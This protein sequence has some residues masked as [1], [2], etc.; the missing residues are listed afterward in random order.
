MLR[1]LRHMLSEAYCLGLVSRHIFKTYHGLKG[2]VSF[3]AHPFRLLIPAYTDSGCSGSRNA[4]LPMQA[5]HVE[6][7][8]AWPAGYMTVCIVTTA[9]LLNSVVFKFMKK[10]MNLR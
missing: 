9:I 4:L 1:Y 3:L 8:S 7:T 6:D 2:H 5:T 10:S